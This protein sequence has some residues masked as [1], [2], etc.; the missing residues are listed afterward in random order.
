MG[1]SNRIAHRRD[2]LRGRAE[3]IFV[4]SQLDDLGRRAA[5]F[6]RGL[7]DWFA[8]LINSEV[9]Q[10][11]IGPV[12]DR[13]HWHSLNENVRGKRLATVRVLRQPPAMHSFYLIADAIADVPI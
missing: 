5:Q 11:R 13:F 4:R 1:V 12:P 9:A 6:A 7:F 10:L 8:R 3:R 2:R